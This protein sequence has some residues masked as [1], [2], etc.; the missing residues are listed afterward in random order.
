M[1]GHEVADGQPSAAPSGRFDGGGCG[2]G[3]EALLEEL[4]TRGAA[5]FA[6]FA[7]LDVRLTELRTADDLRPHCGN[8]SVRCIRSGP[9][10]ELQAL[11]CNYRQEQ[12]L[13]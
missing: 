4:E 2:A 11:T 10:S 3:A 13:A 8:R 7:R 5:L 1:S 9:Y 6:E 12:E